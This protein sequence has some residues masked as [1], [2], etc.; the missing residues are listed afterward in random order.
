MQA[1]LYDMN[2]ASLILS[3]DQGYTL[4]SLQKNEHSLDTETRRVQREESVCAL[5]GRLPCP[6]QQVADEISALFNHIHKIFYDQSETYKFFLP[7]V[8]RKI[9]F[10]LLLLHDRDMTK[11]SYLLKD[12]HMVDYYRLCVLP[13]PPKDRV[14]AYLQA[15]DMYN[16]VEKIVAPSTDCP[17]SWAAFTVSHWP[18]VLLHNITSILGNNPLTQYLHSMNRTMRNLQPTTDNEEH[19]MWVFVGELLLVC[20]AIMIESPLCTFDDVAQWRDDD[21]LKLLCYVVAFAHPGVD[22]RIDWEA[23]QQSLDTVR[24]SG[25]VESSI[26]RR[27]LVK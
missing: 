6:T 14:R 23:T 11:Y 9:E 27:H 10:L 26:E 19:R 13:Q 16:G 8:S 5:H 2:F 3:I 25:D 15:H 21:H 18:M 17:M 1:P 7:L 22:D 4:G 24:A 12:P 20:I